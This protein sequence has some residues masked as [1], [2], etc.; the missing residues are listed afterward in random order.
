MVH[1]DRVQT[2]GSEDG[3][4]V[5]DKINK[6]MKEAERLFLFDK[7]KNINIPDDNFV[8]LGEIDETLEPGVYMVG[9]SVIWNMNTRIRSAIIRWSLDDGA[10]WMLSQKEAKDKTDINTTTYLFPIE[11]IANK[12]VELRLEMAKET[13]NDVCNVIFSDLWLEKKL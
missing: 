11:V 6:T 2:D 13:P 5:A 7:R 9:F 8:R 10:N 12:L 1:L 3:A 4:S